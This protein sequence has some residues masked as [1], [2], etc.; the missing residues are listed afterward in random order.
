MYSLTDFN[1]SYLW[2]YNDHKWLEEDT[3][4]CCD[5]VLA[6]KAC[7]NAYELMSVPTIII[8][9]EFKRDPTISY[10][11]VVFQHSF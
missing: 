11:T 8:G 3:L 2:M 7:N 6:H 5:Y 1:V 9:K 4:L 10:T